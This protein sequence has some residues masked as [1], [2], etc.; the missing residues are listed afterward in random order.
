MPVRGVSTVSTS[1]LNLP[2]EV[3]WLLC[4]QVAWSSLPLP[5]CYFDLF[6][7]LA[8][9]VFPE[10]LFRNPR[11]TLVD[12]H[13]VVRLPPRVWQAILWNVDGGGK[14]GKNGGGLV[15][16]HSAPF[17]LGRGV[18]SERDRKSRRVNFSHQINANAVF[19]LKYKTAT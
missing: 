10:L 12:C 19:C 14:S 6:F 17:P 3:P 11:Q 4:S 13:Q 15:T 16:F 1:P 9:T 2:S 18:L 8:P 5:S 7:R